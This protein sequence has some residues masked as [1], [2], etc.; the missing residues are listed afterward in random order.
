MKVETDLRMAG[1]DYEAVN[2]A[3]PLK[4]L[5]KKLP[6]IEDAGK[7]IAD[8]GFIVDYL[9]KTYGDKLDANLS[10]TDRAAA[11]VLRHLF[12][13]SLYW[14]MLYSRWME[15]PTWSA[16]RKQFFRRDAAGHQANRPA[17]NQEECAQSVISP[18]NGAP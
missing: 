10:A 4:A 14:V 9:S 15:E 1:I 18:R 5:K 8:S 2:G 17:A 7:A 6:Y 3:S 13:E 11:H 16:V 12:E